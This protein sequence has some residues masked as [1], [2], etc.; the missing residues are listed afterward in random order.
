MRGGGGWGR[1]PPPSFLNFGRLGRRFGSEPKCVFDSLR[2]LL[3][4]V[5]IPRA[6]PDLKQRVGLV[7]KSHKE[8]T[9]NIET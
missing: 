9:G 3:T 4:S 1:S 8:D 7:R 6:S 5:I 2:L